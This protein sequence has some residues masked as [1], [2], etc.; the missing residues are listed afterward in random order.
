MQ[1][2]QLKRRNFIALLG[3][4][5][6][7]WP[8]N[9]RAQQPAMPVVGFVNGQSQETSVRRVGAFRKALNEAGYVEGQKV[10][11]EYRWLDGE[12]D[13]LPPLMADL[14][15]RHVAVI[16]TPGGNPASLAAK[17]ATTT[18]PI[19]SASVQTRSRWVLSPASL[20]RAATRP[21]SIF[22]SRISPPSGWGCCTTWC[23]RPFVSPCLS[24][25]RVLAPELGCGYAAT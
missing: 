2:D 16:A 17:A 11:V 7:A 12:Y 23:P 8:R 18:I 14:A 5:V 13:R 10:T 9:A 6:A 21:A 15:R 22:S 19:V 4:A 20:G 25:R 24:I 1:F 3:G